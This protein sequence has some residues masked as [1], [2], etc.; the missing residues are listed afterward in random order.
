MGCPPD[1]VEA[2]LWRGND[3]SKALKEKA[4]VLIPQSKAAAKFLAELCI[5]YPE[6]VPALINSKAKALN[7]DTSH[8]SP[9]HLGKTFNWDNF[10]ESYSGYPDMSVMN[11]HLDDSEKYVKKIEITLCIIRDLL[12]KTVGLIGENNLSETERKKYSEEKNF[13]LIHRRED[14]EIKLKTLETDIST[15]QFV[16]TTKEYNYTEEERK[17]YSDKLKLLEPEL[18]RIQALS[19]DE[20]L[21]NRELF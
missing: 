4:V 12:L 14:K 1:P 6:A 7:I 3:N 13:H 11:A 10:P 2:S 19:N 15:C 9:S 16:M 17:Q 20:L 8:F 21:N 5:A 18:K